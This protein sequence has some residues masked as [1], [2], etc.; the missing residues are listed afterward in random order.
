V[1]WGFRG[2]ALLEQAGARCIVDTVP[3]LLAVAT[4]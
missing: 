4:E 3:E 2:R 1:A